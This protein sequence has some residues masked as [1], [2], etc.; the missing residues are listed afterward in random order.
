M[1]TET[2][3]A[4]PPFDYQAAVMRWQTTTRAVTQRY[5]DLYCSA[6][7]SHAAL[8]RDVADAHATAIRG[9]IDA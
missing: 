2:A 5:L 1:S 9:L 6:V 7:V 3:F 8:H 4:Q